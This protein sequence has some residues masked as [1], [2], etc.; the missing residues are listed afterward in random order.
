MEEE[1]IKEAQNPVRQ[2]LFYLFI[3]LLNCILIFFIYVQ[4]FKG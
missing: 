3:I 2:Q 4:H 1:N